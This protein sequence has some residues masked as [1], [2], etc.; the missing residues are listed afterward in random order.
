MII[1]KTYRD[2]CIDLFS[3]NMDLQACARF[4]I[5]L[6][7]WAVFQFAILEKCRRLLLRA[8]PLI[9][10][11]TGILV[12]ETMT[13]KASGWDGLGWAILTNYLAYG[14]LGDLC[15]AILWLIR[16]R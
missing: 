12:G 2:L 9:L 14:L 1:L 5:L 6:A 8:L 15:G 16:Q 13:V 3:W 7:P 11:L 4:L 10:V